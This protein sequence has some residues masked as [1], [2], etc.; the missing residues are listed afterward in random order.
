[1]VERTPYLT[2][3]EAAKE[4]RV[5]P[6]MVYRMVKSGELAHLRAGPRAIRIPRSALDALVK[7]SQTA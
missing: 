4:L 7:H 5:H 2:V 1:V 3:A 6:Q